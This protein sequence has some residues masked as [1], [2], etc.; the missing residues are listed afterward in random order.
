MNAAIKDFSR[1]SPAGLYALYREVYSSSTGMSETLEEKYPSIGDFIEAITA[2]QR[3]CSACREPWRWRRRSTG[4][5][6]PS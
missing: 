2:L 3:P 1:C 4:R 6:G 5:R